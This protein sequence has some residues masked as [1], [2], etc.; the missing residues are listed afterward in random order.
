MHWKAWICVRRHGR[1]SRGFLL[2][3]NKTAEKQNK[4]TLIGDNFGW[5]IIK[6]F[7][8]NGSALMKV[9]LKVRLWSST[10]DYYFDNSCLEK[11]SFLG[12]SCLQ[13]GKVLKYRQIIIHR[14]QNDGKA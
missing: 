3:F 1:V 12:P 9:M 8:T 14:K 4:M 2:V 11:Y 10:L 6:N 13:T 7:W 5:Y